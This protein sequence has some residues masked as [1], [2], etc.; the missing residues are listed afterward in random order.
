MRQ[1][2]Q[3]HITKL[4]DLGDALLNALLHT[5]NDIK[6]SSSNYRPL[7]PT[8]PSLHHNRSIVLAVL[9]DKTY[10]VVLNCTWNRYRLEDIGVYDSHFNVGQRFNSTATVRRIMDN[11]ESSLKRTLTE[12]SETLFSSKVD[13]IKTIVKQIKGEI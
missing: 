5:L 10:W 2:L 7:I 4:D 9:R 8:I 3:Q 11:I 13:H 12:T 1:P 6:C